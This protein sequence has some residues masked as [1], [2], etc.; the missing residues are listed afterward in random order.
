[1]S[2]TYVRNDAVEG[3][4]LVAIAVDA[5]GQLSEVLRG[6][7]N[8]VVVELELNASFRRAVDCYVELGARHIQFSVKHDAKATYE[9]VGPNDEGGQRFQS[10]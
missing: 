4:A 2:H 6:L 7:R 3:A 8:Y 9:D 5:G 10:Q 1:M